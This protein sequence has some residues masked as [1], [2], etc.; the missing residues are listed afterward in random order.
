[1]DLNIK[2]SGDAAVVTVKGDLSIYTVPAFYTEI[3]P[4]IEENSKIALDLSG[5][6]ELDTTA[7]QALMLLKKECVNR[8]KTLKLMNH[9]TV[10]VKIFDLLGLIGY[11]G[12]KIKIPNEEREQFSFKYGMKK[13]VIY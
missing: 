1:M 3:K 12:D 13:Q 11:F 9:S 2:R 8:D 6:S 7:V 5:V 10:V 4:V